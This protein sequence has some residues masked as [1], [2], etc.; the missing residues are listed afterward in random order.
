MSKASHNKKSNY[1]DYNLLILIVFL[2]CFGLVMLFSSSSYIAANKYG[3]SA[4]FLKMQMR[5]IGVG[6]LLMI[7]LIFIDYRVWKRFAILAYIGSFLLCC[8]VLVIILNKAL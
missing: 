4:Y 1:F 8:V 6:L 2:L 5:N 3:D 7:P